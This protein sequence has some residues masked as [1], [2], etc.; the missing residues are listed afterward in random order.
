[1]SQQAF[2]FTACCSWFLIRPFN[3]D[4]GPHDGYLVQA[5]TEA[6]AVADLDMGPAESV[7]RES[8]E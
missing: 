3:Y 6:E 2:D 5:A 8:E 7:E 1:M 4:G